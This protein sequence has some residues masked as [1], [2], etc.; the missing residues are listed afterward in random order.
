MNH[1]Y[2]FCETSPVRPGLSVAGARMMAQRNT[3]GVNGT[4]WVQLPWGS[5]REGQPAAWLVS[6]VLTK[7]G[8]SCPVSPSHLSKAGSLAHSVLLDFR[9]PCLCTPCPHL[10]GVLGLF[11]WYPFMDQILC[12]YFYQ[13]FMWGKEASSY[14][15]SGFISATC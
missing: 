10:V 5:M 14:F 6:P 4:N 2:A 1:E 12:G 7:P 9:R 8:T 13:K 15:C 11:L 3:W